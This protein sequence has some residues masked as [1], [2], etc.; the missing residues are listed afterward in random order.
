M[1]K[2]VVMWKFKEGTE[3]QA[4]EFIDGLKGLMGVVEVLR[5]VEV[6]LNVNPN[7]PFGGVLICTFDNMDDLNS[8]AKDP[9]HLAV[10]ALCKPIR[11]ERVAVDFEY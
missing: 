5:S 3:K 4:Q 10:A 11:T 6:G 8:Y 9:R 1:I 2:H 7:E